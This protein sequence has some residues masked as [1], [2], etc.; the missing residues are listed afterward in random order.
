MVE[1]TSVDHGG[2]IA[3]PNFFMITI[4]V[5][6]NKLLV[7]IHDSYNGI[8]KLLSTHNNYTVFIDFFV[9]IIV[10]VYTNKLPMH[11]HDS[12][13]VTRKY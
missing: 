4:V 3:C 9:M 1:E 12:Y 11:I 2:Q 13:N 5:Y 8:Y 6:I 7:H 10:A